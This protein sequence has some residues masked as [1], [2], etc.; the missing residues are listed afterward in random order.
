MMHDETNGGFEFFERR[1]VTYTD[2]DSWV[3]EQANI[4]ERLFSTSDFLFGEVGSNFAGDGFA[5]EDGIPELRRAIPPTANLFLLLKNVLHRVREI[6]FGL[7]VD[8]HSRSV[9]RVFKVIFTEISP[10]SFSKVRSP[11]AAYCIDIQGLSAESI[12]RSI[13]PSWRSVIAP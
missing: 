4:S 3:S 10:R 2:S 9:T 6:A 12:C 7:D 5:G 8:P 11:A 1:T 13:M